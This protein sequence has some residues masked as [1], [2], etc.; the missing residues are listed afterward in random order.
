[1]AGISGSIGRAGAPA[2]I[3]A[4]ALA[5]AAP[6]ARA[7]DAKWGD[8]RWY[9]GFAIPVM[10]IDDTESTTAGSQ[11]LNPLALSTRASYRSKSTSSYETGFKV[12]GTVG[13]ELGGGFRVEGELFFARAEVE[14]VVYTGVE[15]DFGQIPLSVN[16]PVSGT[17]DQLGAFASAWYDIRTGTDWIPYIGAGLGVIRIDQGGLEYDSQKLFRDAVAAMKASQIQGT[18]NLPEPENLPVV[19]DIST[20]DTV[21]AYHVGIGTGYRL[22]DNVILQA[23]YRFQTATDL[24]FEG[25]NAAG[26]VDVTSGMRVHLFEIGVRYRF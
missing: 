14:K 5:A 8:G 11:A 1:M 12:A 26:S 7:A 6:D 25:R 21:L 10:F 3:L 24:E 9:A 18:E 15:T 20:T 2:A 16:V 13:C 19:P 17:A 23:G 22:T 4:L